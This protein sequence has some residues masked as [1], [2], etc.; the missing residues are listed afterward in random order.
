MYQLVK[1]QRK[2]QI[3]I[4]LQ[5]SGWCTSCLVLKKMNDLIMHSLLQAA[6]CCLKTKDS[7]FFGWGAAIRE[8]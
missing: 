6:S 7:L 8:H 4:G 3:M 2:S 5:L 1:P